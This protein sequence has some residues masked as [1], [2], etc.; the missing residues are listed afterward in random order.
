[1]ILYPVN[2]SAIGVGNTEMPSSAYE[3]RNG[4]SLHIIAYNGDGTIY[5]GA[6]SAVVTIYSSNVPCKGTS[7]NLDPT[8]RKI[9][10]SAYTLNA[11]I[12]QVMVDLANK[13]YVNLIVE[14]TTNANAIPITCYPTYGF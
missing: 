6:N 11:A 8:F 3:Q 12:P 4:E 13:R 2:Q 9:V 7:T 5:S 14:V 1:M 10:G